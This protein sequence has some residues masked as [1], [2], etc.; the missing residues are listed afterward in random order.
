MIP[1]DQKIRVEG[2]LSSETYSMGIREENLREIMRITTDLYSD[3]ELAFIREYSTNAYDSHV[4]AGTPEKPIEVFLPNPLR[5]TFEV[6]DY[7]LGLSVDEIV[8]VFGSYGAS[9]KR[10]RNDANGCLGLGSK[11]ALTYTSM[12]TVSAVKNGVRSEVAIR[13]DNITGGSIEV[14]DT[15][16]TDEPNGVRVTIPTSVDA[17]FDDKAREFYQYWPSGT[18]LID[19]TPNVNITETVEGFWIDK[20]TFLRQVANRWNGGD[21]KIIMGNVA[22]PADLEIRRNYYESWEV[23]YFADMAEVEFVP[24]REALNNT[25]MVKQVLRDLASRVGSVQ[26]ANY[27]RSLPVNSLHEAGLIYG[28]AIKYLN[29]FSI[30]YQGAKIKASY[31]LHHRLYSPAQ[32]IGRGGG[33]FTEK[34]QDIYLEKMKNY[35]FIVGNMNATLSPSNRD[36]IEQLVGK[37]DDDHRFILVDNMA[38]VPAIFLDCKQYLWEDVIAIKVASAP[39]S[40]SNSPTKKIPEYDYAVKGKFSNYGV[41]PNTGT[42]YWVSNMDVMSNLAQFLRDDEHL[43]LVYSTRQEKF[44]RLYPK[45]IGGTYLREREIKELPKLTKQEMLARHLGFRGNIFAENIDKIDDPRVQLLGKY[46]KNSEQQRINSLVSKYQSLGQ[47]LPEYKDWTRDEYPLLNVNHK[48][49]SV[50]YM[51]AIYQEKN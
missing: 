19:G 22:Y 10:D 51:N 30:E 31:K 12:F 49:H 5:Q 20:K 44:L 26:V 11:S 25:P 7:G 24:S 17:N 2:N 23:L 27:F 6:Q 43:V 15:R 36:R 4:M 8:N 21:H 16:A 18:V 29:D 41:L 14:I 37:V 48:K 45:A 35:S 32:N 47:K 13:R 3:N 9:T 1:V 42:L 40:K 39:R 50:I 33:K 34:G 28:D 38:S 46:A